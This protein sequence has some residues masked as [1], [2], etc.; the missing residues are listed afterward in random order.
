MYRWDFMDRKVGLVLAAD[1]GWAKI[2][3][4]PKQLF[5]FGGFGKIAGWLVFLRRSL[6]EV[7][8]WTWEMLRLGG[9]IWKKPLDSTPSDGTFRDFGGYFVSVW[10]IFFFKPH[11]KHRKHSF[12]IWFQFWGF[13][14]FPWVLQS[15][16]SLGWNLKP[17]Y[18]SFDSLCGLFFT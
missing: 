6:C 1:Q 13:L 3:G 4:S 14:L 10:L 17:I 15:V 18:V 2:Y 11:R 12:K 8:V 9:N 16:G 7:E 5:R